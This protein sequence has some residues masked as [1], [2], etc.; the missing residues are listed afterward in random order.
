MLTKTLIRALTLV[1]VFAFTA[2]GS[3]GASAFCP[4]DGDEPS[5]PTSYCPGDGDE[6]SGPTSYC[7]GD[8]D[9]PTEPT[10]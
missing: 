8:G 7:P 3:V 4:G 10:T 6:P 2:I 1:T 5:G 9:E